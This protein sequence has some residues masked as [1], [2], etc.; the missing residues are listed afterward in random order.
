MVVE[1]AFGLEHSGARGENVG[2]SFF[3]RSLSCR[4]RHARQRFTPELSHRGGQRL[5]GYKRVFNGQQA[6]LFRISMQLIFLDYRC[7]SSFFQS[8]GH[9]VVTIEALTFD[10][11]EK[12]S[13]SDRARVDGIPLRNFL[14]WIVA[15]ADRREPALSLSKGARRYLSCRGNKLGDFR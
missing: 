9:I 10:S 3:G 14:A 1:I 4:T 5:Q 8:G 7:C 2:N 15:L 11:K 13:L 12:F 6:G